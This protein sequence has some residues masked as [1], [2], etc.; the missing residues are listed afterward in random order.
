V[1]L[2]VDLAARAE[3]RRSVAWYEEQCPGLGAEFAGTVGRALTEVEDAPERWPTWRLEPRVRR[4]LLQRFPFAIV[5][6]IRGGD[7]YVVAIAHTRRSPRQWLASLE[8]AAKPVRRKRKRK[9]L[10]GLFK[11]R[12]QIHGD[13]AEVNFADLWH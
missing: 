2:L 1:K 8:S 6:V 10:R 5:Y 3:L 9:R 11:S 4:Y 13:I 7:P 12:L